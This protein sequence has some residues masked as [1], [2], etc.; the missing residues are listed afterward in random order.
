MGQGRTSRL[1]LLPIKYRTGRTDVPTAAAGVTISWLSESSS[2]R[3]GK[4]ILVN[5]TKRR[6]RRSRRG[7][8]CV[9]SGRQ[10]LELNVDCLKLVHSKAGKHI[11]LLLL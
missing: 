11:I 9:V 2:E 5:G 1:R 3:K 8:V 10:E 6:N 7:V 4:E